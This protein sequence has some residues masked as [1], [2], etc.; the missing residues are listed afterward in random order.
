MKNINAKRNRPMAESISRP[1]IVGYGIP[2]I[3]FPDPK[4]VQLL[5]NLSK[6]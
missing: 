4:T 3:P 1:K 2:G 6:I 5:A